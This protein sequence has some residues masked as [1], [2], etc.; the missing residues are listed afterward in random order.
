MSN[1]KKKGKREE[2]KY[3]HTSRMFIAGVIIMFASIGIPIALNLE[4]Q[5][6]L[7]ISAVGMFI[8]IILTIP[9]FRNMVVK[10]DEDGAG[11]YGLY[12]GKLIALPILAILTLVYIIRRII[13]VWGV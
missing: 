6:E 13:E 2:K 8:A 4:R 7:D 10:L 12:L 11:D 9:A 1:K 3:P 5:L